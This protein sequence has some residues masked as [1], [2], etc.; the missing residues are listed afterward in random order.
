MG[1]MKCVR[2]TNTRIVKKQLIVCLNFKFQLEK[3]FL[4]SSSVFP[5]LLEGP[6]HCWWLSQIPIKEVPKN[7][8]EI[9]MTDERKKTK[10]ISFHQR[11]PT[12]QTALSRMP[13]CPSCPL[14]TCLAICCWTETM[15]Q[16]F[17]GYHFSPPFSWAGKKRA[18]LSMA[19]EG[20]VKKLK[21]K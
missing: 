7:S 3:N 6:R 5:N 2:G 14:W 12:K 10:K 17:Y 9:L 16:D 18:P 19:T 11:T 13:L 1:K 8:S 21:K 4:T 15:P 20:T